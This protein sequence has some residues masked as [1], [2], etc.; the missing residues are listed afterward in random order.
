MEVRKIV[1]T[2]AYVFADDVDTEL[3]SLVKDGDY[4]G[5]KVSTSSVR[6]YDTTAAAHVLGIV[7]RI[8]EQELA[9][10]D[11][12]V[13]NGEDWIGR[14]GVELAFEDYLRGTDGKRLITSN[15]EG[16]ITS[17]IYTT[18]PK[19]GKTV[20]LTL[21]LD[22]QE[23]T[24]QALADTIT[25]MNKDGNTT[26]G[27]RR[28]DQVGTGEVLAL[29]SYPTFNLAT[30]NQDYS[31]LRTDPSK[32]YNNR[33]TMGLYAPGST[34]KPC[35]AT[36]ALESGVVTLTETIRCTGR[37]YYPDMIEGTEPFSAWCWKRGS[38]GPLNITQ[39][40]TNSCNFSFIP[41]ATG[42]ELTGWTN[43]PPPLA[44]GAR[45][46]L[47]S[48]MTRAS[49]LDRSIRSPSVRHGTAAIP[50]WP[51]SANP[52]TCLLPFSW[53]TIS[54]LWWMVAITTRPTF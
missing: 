9:S 51:L 28:S 41:W 11:P 50:S 2:T 39:A 6:E 19:P 29:A 32:P 37:W 4:R 40:I 22:L 15:S 7:G 8:N 46:A 25:D 53:P 12:N 3:I 21:D 48:V 1:N 13:Y 44:L 49:W 47:R 5:A 43:M 23:A 30:Y 18:E 27:A 26:R 14:S 45:P 16:K 10:A 38:H 33:A 17:E 36:A 20:A 31:K 42:L 34:F 35:T 52:I 24:E 54:P